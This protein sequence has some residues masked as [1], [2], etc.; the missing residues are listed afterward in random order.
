[1]YPKGTGVRE[2]NANGADSHN[3]SSSRGA[4]NIP[5]GYSDE[6]SRFSRGNASSVSINGQYSSA[7]PTHTVPSIFVNA[8]GA[9]PYVQTQSNTRP[10]SLSSDRASIYSSRD[11][12]MDTRVPKSSHTLTTTASVLTRNVESEKKPQLPITMPHMAPPPLP[13]VARS[14]FSNAPTEPTATSQQPRASVSSLLKPPP[15]FSTMARAPVYSYTRHTGQPSPADITSG[16][17]I[18]NSLKHSTPLIS[19]S[20]E[21][22]KSAVTKADL[23]ESG[24]NTTRRSPH[25]AQV[26]QSVHSLPPSQPPASARLPVAS[27]PQ[28]T[29]NVPMSQSSV[30]TANATAGMTSLSHVNPEGVFAQYIFLLNHIYHLPRHVLLPV[31]S[32][33]SILTLSS[34]IQNSTSLPRPTSHIPAVS[35]PVL[36]RIITLALRQMT[37]FWII[38][39][40]SVPLKYAYLF[41]E[42]SIKGM[43]EK[44]V[45]GSYTASSHLSGTNM[46]SLFTDS[47]SLQMSYQAFVRKTHREFARKFPDVASTGVNATPASPLSTSAFFLPPQPSPWAS[48]FNLFT[49]A[50]AVVR[51]VEKIL[52]IGNH[53]EKVTNF[54]NNINAFLGFPQMSVLHPSSTLAM[55]SMFFSPQDR[56]RS[57]HTPSQ[58]PMLE[59]TLLFKLFVQFL[60][61]ASHSM[62]GMCINAIPACPDESYSSRLLATVS[63]TLHTQS[64]SMDN[65]AFSRLAVATLIQRPL[66]LHRWLWGS[67]S[68]RK[69]LTRKAK[70]E[71]TILSLASWCENVILTPSRMGEGIVLAGVA[72]SLE[73]FSLISYSE[74]L[75]GGN[76]AQQT[77]IVS[78]GR[79]TRVPAVT[80]SKALVTSILQSASSYTLNF[81]RVMTFLVDVGL[82]KLLRLPLYVWAT[83]F[84]MCSQLEEERAHSPSSTRI[85]HEGQSNVRAEHAITDTSEKDVPVPLSPAS[86]DR[87]LKST[88]SASMLPRFLSL[89]VVTYVIDVLSNDLPEW[90][91]K[92]TSVLQQQ[93]PPS[94]PLEEAAVEFNDS[95]IPY[96]KFI[97]VYDF[98]KVKSNVQVVKKQLLTEVLTSEAKGT[99]SLLSLILT[100]GSE[101]PLESTLYPRGTA[102][103]GTERHT[104]E[105]RDSVQEQL[106]ASK[107]A[108]PAL[109]S[110]LLAFSTVRLL[111]VCQV[112]AS[113]LTKAKVEELLYS[114]TRE[115]YSVNARTSSVAGAT[116]SPSL[117]AANHGGGMSTVTSIY[118]AA[119]SSE[120][121]EDVDDRWP[122][123]LLLEAGKVLTSR[124]YKVRSSDG[125]YNPALATNTA[126]A[127]YDADKTLRSTHQEDDK[128]DVWDRIIS[129]GWKEIILLQ[130][131]LYSR[132]LKAPLPSDYVTRMMNR[133]PTVA[134]LGPGISSKN[135]DYPSIG[136]IFN[137][138]WANIL[139][140]WVIPQRIHKFASLSASALPIYDDSTS[141]SDSDIEMEDQGVRVKDN[142]FGM[143]VELDMIYSNPRMFEKQ[144]NFKQLGMEHDEQFSRWLVKRDTNLA[145]R[146]IRSLSVSLSNIHTPLLQSPAIQGQ[147]GRLSQFIG[148]SP[149]RSPSLSTQEV[150][151]R[152]ST[153]PPLDLLEVVTPTS[154]SQDGLRI[155]LPEQEMHLQLRS[156][157]AVAP[158][159]LPLPL[160]TSDK[161]ADEQSTTTVPRADMED[162]L[163]SPTQGRVDIVPFPLPDCPRVRILPSANFDQL[164]KANESVSTTVMSIRNALIE[165]A[166]AR[167]QIMQKDLWGDS[168]VSKKKRT[169]ESGKHSIASE[170]LPRLRKRNESKNKYDSHPSKNLRGNAS[171]VSAASDDVTS[172]MQTRAG[173]A[174]KAQSYLKKKNSHNLAMVAGHSR[175]LTAM[176]ASGT[177][178]QSRAKFL[179]DIS[180]KRGSSVYQSSSG[181]DNS[182]DNVSVSEYTDSDQDTFYSDYS[183]E[184]DEYSLEVLA[185]YPVDGVL[186]RLGLVTTFRSKNA[187][188]SATEES[189]TSIHNT[190]EEDAHYSDSTQ[191]YDSANRLSSNDSESVASFSS[192]ERNPRRLRKWMDRTSENI[193]E[194]DVEHGPMIMEQAMEFLNDAVSDE[195]EE[196][197]ASDVVLS[198]RG[199]QPLGNNRN[200]ASYDDNDPTS[201][202]NL[203]IRA[204]VPPIW[205]AGDDDSL[206]D[207][208]PIACDMQ[209]RKK[210][211]IKY[212]PVELFALGFSSASEEESDYHMKATSQ[213]NEEIDPND[214]DSLYKSPNSEQKRNR[215]AAR[216]SKLRKEEHDDPLSKSNDI[217]YDTD[218]S[219]NS[220]NWVDTTDSEGDAD[221]QSQQTMVGTYRSISASNHGRHNKARYQDTDSALKQQVGLAHYPPSSDTDA[222]VT[223]SSRRAHS[224]RT[225]KG[226]HHSGTRSSYGDNAS[227]YHSVSRSLNYLD[228]ASDGA[229]S[230]SGATGDVMNLSG[231]DSAKLYTIQSGQYQRNPPFTRNNHPYLPTSP[232]STLNT[233][234][235]HREGFA[236][237][238]R[239]SPYSLQGSLSDR[240]PGDIPGGEYQTLRRKRSMFDLNEARRH[241]SMPAKS[242][243]DPIQEQKSPSKDHIKSKK[244]GPSDA[245]T[246]NGERKGVGSE[247]DEKPSSAVDTHSRHRSTPIEE[248]GLCTDCW[249]MPSK[250]LEELD[251]LQKILETEMT[252]LRQKMEMCYIWDGLEGIVHND[253]CNNSPDCLHCLVTNQRLD[254]HTTP[255]GSGKRSVLK[256]FGQDPGT[257]MIYVHA[258]YPPAIAEPQVQFMLQN[259]VDKTIQ[260]LFREEYCLNDL[261]LAS[262]GANFT[263]TKGPTSSTW[264]YK[265]LSTSV[266]GSATNLFPYPPTFRPANSSHENSSI[267]PVLDSNYFV[268]PKQRA[269]SMKGINLMIPPSPLHSTLSDSVE[270]ATLS[271]SDGQTPSVHSPSFRLQKGSSF[272]PNSVLSSPNVA[273]NLANPLHPASVSDA[274]YS[275]NSGPSR[276]LKNGY[277]LPLLPETPTPVWRGSVNEL[278]P[279][280]GGRTTTSTGGI[281]NELE[282]SETIQLPM[283]RPSI[284]WTE[285]H[286]ALLLLVQ[287]ELKSEA[288]EWKCLADRSAIALASKVTANPDSL[289]SPI[290]P[291][292]VKENQVGNTFATRKKKSD[293]SFAAQ[294]RMGDD[295][296]QTLLGASATGKQTQGENKH[297]NKAKKAVQVSI[298]VPGSECEVD[299]YVGASTMIDN[300]YLQALEH[301]DKCISLRSLWV[302]ALTTLSKI[303]T[304]RAL[305]IVPQTLHVSAQVTT[306]PLINLP[307]PHCPFLY[308]DFGD[309][310]MGNASASF[311]ITNNSASPSF[312]ASEIPG[313]LFSVTASRNIQTFFHKRHIVVALLLSA[314]EAAK[315]A[316]AMEVELKM[317]T[318][319]TSSPTNSPIQPNKGSRH[320]TA[321]HTPTGDEGL[322]H[323]TSPIDEEKAEQNRI[324]VHSP[325]LDTIE[326]LLLIHMFLVEDVPLLPNFGIPMLEERN[327][328]QIRE[329][330]TGPSVSLAPRSTPKTDDESQGKSSS[331]AIRTGNF[332]WSPTAASA[333][334]MRIVVSSTHPHVNSAEVSESA[335]SGLENTYETTKLR[336]Q[337]N[338]PLEDISDSPTVWK[339]Q[340][341]LPYTLPGHSRE[342]GYT[343]QDRKE[344]LEIMSKSLLQGILN[345]RICKSARGSTAQLDDGKLAPIEVPGQSLDS[346]STFDQLIERGMAVSNPF[347]DDDPALTTTSLSSIGIS[348]VSALFDTW[349]KDKDGLLKGD[350]LLHAWEVLGT[351]PVPPRLSVR[352]E[353]K[354]RH[355]TKGYYDFTTEQVLSV[356]YE[357]DESFEFRP[358]QHERGTQ[359]PNHRIRKAMQ[360]AH[361]PRKKR[362]KVSRTA[363][364]QFYS[365]LKRAKTVQSI[366]TWLGDAFGS[367]YPAT[368]YDTYTSSSPCSTLVPIFMSTNPTSSST[369]NKQPI[370]E[371]PAAGE[372]SE[373]V[374]SG[375]VA[376][377]Q[378]PSAPPLT[379]TTWG[380]PIAET[381]SDV[382]KRVFL[383]K[384]RIRPNPTKDE[385]RKDNYGNVHSNQLRR[386]IS[387]LRA[388]SKLER[389]MYQTLTYSNVHRSF[390]KSFYAYSA[391]VFTQQLSPRTSRKG[392]RVYSQ[393]NSAP[394]TSYAE[395]QPEQAVS[396]VYLQLSKEH[397]RSFLRK[398]SEGK[399]KPKF[400]SSPYN[401]PLS[402]QYRKHN[403]LTGVRLPTLTR[404]PTL[405]YSNTV[406]GPNT[407]VSLHTVLQYCSWLAVNNPIALARAFFSANIF[408]PSP[409]LDSMFFH[410]ENTNMKHKSSFFIPRVTTPNATLVPNA[411]DQAIPTNAASSLDGTKNP[412]P[413]PA[414][415]EAG[416]CEA[417]PSKAS[418][419]P[420]KNSDTL[421]FHT[422]VVS[423]SDSSDESESVAIAPLEQRAES[424]FTFACVL[425]PAI[426]F[427]SW[428]ADASFSLSLQSILLPDY[429]VT[430]SEFLE[431]RRTQPTR[432]SEVN[433]SHR[434]NS[435]PGFTHP[436]VSIPGNKHAAS[437]R[438]STG[439]SLSALYENQS[440]IT[441]TIIGGIRGS[442]ESASDAMKKDGISTV[443]TPRGSTIL[444]RHQ[445]DSSEAYAGQVAHSPGTDE[446]NT[447]N[448]YQKKPTNNSHPISTST[449]GKI[450]FNPSLFAPNS[451]VTSEFQDVHGS[452]DARIRPIGQRGTPTALS[453]EDMSMSVQTPLQLV[454]AATELQESPLNVEQTN[455]ARSRTQSSSFSEA[456]SVFKDGPDGKQSK[457]IKRVSTP[458]PLTEAYTSES[459]SSM[460]SKHQMDNWALQ[461]YSYLA[462]F[463]TAT[464]TSSSDESFLDNDP[465]YELPEVQSTLVGKSS[466][467]LETSN[468]LNALVRTHSSSN[469]SPLR[470]A[471]VSPSALSYPIFIVPWSMS[472]KVGT[473]AAAPIERD[474]STSMLYGPFVASDI[475]FYVY[476][477]EPEESE[478]MVQILGSS[479]PGKQEVAT[480]TR[481]SISPEV[482][483]T[484]TKNRQSPKSQKTVG[485]RDKR[486]SHHVENSSSEDERSMQHIATWS[487]FRR[488]RADIQALHTSAQ[489]VGSIAQASVFDWRKEGYLYKASLRRKKK[490]TTNQTL[491]SNQSSQPCSPILASK[492]RASND[493]SRLLDLHDRVR[494][495]AIDIS[496]STPQHVDATLGFHENTASLR[497]IQKRRSDSPS[498]STINIAALASGSSGNLLHSSRSAQ[499]L[500]SRSFQSVHNMQLYA[501]EMEQKD[502]SLL[503]TNSGVSFRP[504]SDTAFTFQSFHTDIGGLDLAIP[505][506]IFQTS[507]STS[508]RSSFGNAD[509]LPGS[510]SRNVSDAHID[511]HEHM[512]ASKTPDMSHRNSG[513]STPSAQFPSKASSCAPSR[514]TLSKFGTSGEHNSHVSVR[515]LLQLS[516][517]YGSSRNLLDDSRLSPMTPSAG[518]T[519]G[520]SRTISM[521]ESIVGSSGHV[522]SNTPSMAP[523]MAG[524]MIPSE[525]RLEMSIVHLKQVENCLKD[526]GIIP[527]TRFTT[528]YLSRLHKSN[529]STFYNVFS[530]KY[531][532]STPLSLSVSR[533]EY[534]EQLQPR[535]QA[536]AETAS[537][538][539]TDEPNGIVPTPVP[540]IFT[541]VSVDILLGNLW[542]YSAGESVCR[543]DE[544]DLVL[545]PMSAYY[546]AYYATA[547]NI[548]HAMAGSSSSAQRR[549]SERSL[550]FLQNENFLQDIN[551]FGDGIKSQH[552]IIASITPMHPSANASSRSL[553][554]T[555]E[556]AN[557]SN[558][559]NSSFSGTAYSPDG[560][561]VT[562]HYSI[563]FAPIVLD[564][565]LLQS[566]KLSDKRARHSIVGVPVAI[567]ASFPISEPTALSDADNASRAALNASDVRKY[568]SRQLQLDFNKTTSKNST[569]SAL[570]R[571]I[572][573][574]QLSRLHTAL[575]VLLNSNYVS[576]TSASILYLYLLYTQSQVQRRTALMSQLGA[577]G[578][579]THKQ[580][581]QGVRKAYTAATSNLAIRNKGGKG[582]GKSRRSSNTQRSEALEKQPTVTG[583]RKPSL[584]TSMPS[585]S[586]LAPR[587]SPLSRMFE[588]FVTVGRGQLAYGIYPLDTTRPED[589]EFEPVIQ[590]KFP[591][592]EWTGQSLPLNLGM[593]AFP[594]GLRIEVDTCPAPS[595]FTFALTSEDGNKLY[596]ACLTHWT[597]MSP[598]EIISMF[599]IPSNIANSSY[600]LCLPTWLD[601]KDFHSPEWIENH[602][603]YAPR[604]YILMSRFPLYTALQSTLA[605]IGKLLHLDKP[606]DWIVRSLEKPLVNSGI[607]A[608]VYSALSSSPTSVGTFLSSNPVMQSNTHGPSLLSSTNPANQVPRSRPVIP[609]ATISKQ[610]LNPHSQYLAGMN[611]D[612]LRN[613]PLADIPSDVVDLIAHLLFDVPSPPAG[614]FSV[615]YTLGDKHF[616]VSRPPPNTLPLLDV[617]V[618]LLFQC[619]DSQNI[620][621]VFTA[622]ATEN[623]ICVCSKHVHILTPVCEALQSFIFPFQLEANY[624]P[625]LPLSMGDILAA[626]TPYLIGWPST[627]EDAKYFTNDC[628]FVDLDEN[629]VWIPPEIS[630]PKLPEAQKNK[631]LKAIRL[632]AYG[633]MGM[634]E[635][636]GARSGWFGA[637]PTREDGPFYGAKYNLDLL[638]RLPRT[639]LAYPEAD[640]AVSASQENSNVPNAM[641]SPLGPRAS[642]GATG[643]KEFNRQL[644]ANLLKSRI[645]Q[646][647]LQN[648]DILT[649]LCPLAQA[650][651]LVCSQ[652]SEK[653][654]KNM[655]TSLA[656][657]VPYVLSFDALSLSA[658]LSYSPVVGSPWLRYLGTAMQSFAGNLHVQH[659]LSHAVST[660][661]LYGKLNVPFL[662]SMEQYLNSCLLNDAQSNKLNTSVDTKTSMS[663]ES[664]SDASIHDPSNEKLNRTSDTA[665]NRTSSRT[666]IRSSSVQNG[667]NVHSYTANL[668]HPIPILDR[669][670]NRDA[671]DPNPVSSAGSD[672]ESAASTRATSARS[673]QSSR[674]LFGTEINPLASVNPALVLSPLLYGWSWSLASQPP[675]SLPP[676]SSISNVTLTSLY[677]MQA[678]SNSTGM[679][680]LYSQGGSTSALPSVQLPMHPAF[681]SKYVSPLQLQH[682]P[683]SISRRESL[684]MP[685]AI[686]GLSAFR[687]SEAAAS[688]VDLDTTMSNRTKVL[689]GMVQ[690]ATS[691]QSIATAYPIPVHVF[692]QTPSEI[693]SGGQNKRLSLKRGNESSSSSVTTRSTSNKRSLAQMLVNTKQSGL[694]QEPMT[695]EEDV[696]NMYTR[697][698]FTNSL[699]DNSFSRVTNPV[700]GLI[701][702]FDPLSVR[703]AFL[704][705]F[706]SLLKY[707]KRFLVYT[708]TGLSAPPEIHALH[709]S[710]ALQKA[711]NRK[712]L[713][714]TST[715]PLSYD[716]AFLHNLSAEV[717]VQT[718]MAS[719]A[720]DSISSNRT[721]QTP[722]DQ[723]NSTTVPTIIPSNNQATQKSALYQ[724]TT[725]S[726]LTSEIMLRMLETSFPMDSLPILRVSFAATE[727]L[728]TVPTE[729][730]EFLGQL[731][732]TQYF[733]D[734][735]QACL[736]K[737]YRPGIGNIGTF[738]TAYMSEDISVTSAPSDTEGKR[739]R[740]RT[741]RPSDVWDPSANDAHFMTRLPSRIRLFDSVVN[742]KLS[743]ISRFGLGLRRG[744][745]DTSF[746]YDSSYHIRRH[747]VVP[748]PMSSIL[749]LLAP[750]TNLPYPN[751]A[752]APVPQN[753]LPS[754]KD[755]LTLPPEIASILYAAVSGFPGD[756]ALLSTRTT[757]LTH[758]WKAGGTTFSSLNYS[759]YTPNK[760]NNPYY[761]PQSE[762]LSSISFT[763]ASTP[764]PEGMHRTHQ[765]GLSGI[766]LGE[767]STPSHLPTQPMNGISDDRTRRQRAYTLER[768]LSRDRVEV[769][770][771]D[772]ATVQQRTVNEK[773][774]LLKKKQKHVQRR[775]AL[776][777]I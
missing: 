589:L 180:L 776:Q 625:I 561:R 406:G 245:N 529:V 238:P 211:R 565:L 591:V 582:A 93:Y 541:P 279:I 412:T 175:Q 359:R 120:K 259:R 166:K 633:D 734:F 671:G 736:P 658:A 652:G 713:Y 526:L 317:P 183:S 756:S 742:D 767:V 13:S 426:A 45:S 409:S 386:R 116:N 223:H 768:D 96:S 266:T 398:R 754:N 91:G 258:A 184:D 545:L 661:S 670:L 280:R 241:E 47:K 388:A 503:R 174:M 520:R 111:A 257:V 498:N 29:R 167:H 139:D 122:T 16:R 394:G 502:S 668:V 343:K 239:K 32:L 654:T 493:S 218:A 666:N 751:A 645:Q 687:Q 605:Q 71:A 597:R 233:L 330:I 297:T 471:V 42:D 585:N 539:N 372:S 726:N 385:F 56:G 580:F 491:R 564:S 431:T 476:S 161:L 721:D 638:D 72:Y 345:P 456:K 7:I 777:N 653:Y 288:I 209:P 473:T 200:S 148:G 533:G 268:G 523:G 712:A 723:S 176:L 649:A 306:P 689:R 201:T 367:P 54:S 27:A 504:R 536:K 609:N 720:F 698:L 760:H 4:A 440:P 535:P 590:E 219:L 757:S 38:Q 397:C 265:T 361:I 676:N 731:L 115:G 422:D 341:C 449:T 450:P 34:V 212:D 21:S 169:H 490:T 114:R 121:E 88:I 255:P 758:S 722:Q 439:S 531:L 240:S 592:L 11:Q 181:E 563:E 447:P 119:R 296:T 664:P 522:S 497:K 286:A 319:T 457:P 626:P 254:V 12:T 642:E 350:E 401:L 352:S 569:M 9:I 579:Q 437:S 774:L 396:K 249:T 606:A 681:A 64:T 284:S 31:H 248:E 708:Q 744:A 49:V 333:S 566:E 613:L 205:S 193:R 405:T 250:A 534:P 327:L 304:K 724:P 462:S 51:N 234:D 133:P 6:S 381:V 435:K 334:L 305:L 662:A 414:S 643:T 568:L 20:L 741:N 310:D 452:F 748:P 634:K 729:A 331:E 617:P 308:P 371:S 420:R 639:F 356:A 466:A 228:A 684:A 477:N 335:T 711:R 98:L 575:S 660:G 376:F 557:A 511:M 382:A 153:L 752:P 438:R 378:R 65:I 227:G 375:I 547:S 624:I 669:F 484:S 107:L 156:K 224:A 719:T 640:D 39:P 611:P 106:L 766:K 770:K 550:L 584:P 746:L 37:E 519:R 35:S 131:N 186:K 554:P 518:L 365:A 659:L 517:M 373:P 22:V 657:L 692:V 117:G 727:F 544:D 15:F 506:I 505:D 347:W 673:P 129:A 650:G 678:S 707:Y 100:Y 630:L 278:I 515:N 632:Y 87:L 17:S 97:S 448:A 383:R 90:K 600:T 237:S 444:T 461:S 730:R 230:D 740:K 363:R 60:I 470:T 61:F 216:M 74:A 311:D 430:D 400:Y 222:S 595:M 323:D 170:I 706:V 478:D 251:R 772:K 41:L 246:R 384:R 207:G 282:K 629:S 434:K 508:T 765:E 203:R 144:L 709:A 607:R 628:I 59:S 298:V 667:M 235:S 443:N 775:R 429:L 157:L 524:V 393:Y 701:N 369:S 509:G 527:P 132:L 187:L 191:S 324:V 395:F 151:N 353:N 283:V 446:I 344:L 43:V 78:Q 355:D 314:R 86:I 105:G 63:K 682:G 312:S 204:N 750:A 171:Y 646:G 262:Q 192:L 603:Y 145:R 81:H 759:A 472:E 328:L 769:E 158:L 130:K 358:Y 214:S 693:L 94:A 58:S 137:T 424:L 351:L 366:Q 336:D 718:A 159:A 540:P 417:S 538:D 277:L 460:E 530:W 302:D 380:F 543:D 300:L 392:S 608:D 548:V 263:Y 631:L 206:L 627:V 403:N 364:K 487:S 48:I 299:T 623:R 196:L 496:K 675:P 182:N 272:V 418:T 704:S 593:F 416:S 469:T 601:V 528:Q 738:G 113:G 480:L 442:V 354:H 691:K 332:D 229:T 615:G 411:P 36:V 95:S 399:K 410:E 680:G 281:A 598:L 309:G 695:T 560:V 415:A 285:Y 44:H 79:D 445:S 340:L 612:E 555:L 247:P 89:V 451:S 261:Y 8:A 289:Q 164:M 165:A 577:Q 441:A 513:L 80:F 199:I 587:T 546:F 586:S 717:A 728:A 275:D 231:S 402:I 459:D 19:T 516:S 558:N 377:F 112:I 696:T 549:N 226:L 683:V 271:M 267:D 101:F 423:P 739:W 663:T 198:E 33:F 177:I 374:E 553:Q 465:Y 655:N 428:L 705:F 162:T 273:R 514:I 488:S 463:E 618:N 542:G 84:L 243:L 70:K 28:P 172:N 85:Y 303:L 620:I 525:G 562:R 651:L 188:K 714:L 495:N 578:A 699:Q 762:L 619:L 337:K 747:W 572:Q 588:Y 326:V 552:E 454:G 690:E 501:S 136:D 737:C 195:G 291:M 260:P 574:P 2:K 419:V 688:V 421:S 559:A 244:H 66:R 315:K 269:Q 127:I 532:S 636:S 362:N 486:R 468:A 210:R 329:N 348:L 360:S 567:P 599:L 507:K 339:V 685:N 338:Q 276:T 108:A 67:D 293:S 656:G 62:A 82:V 610:A 149:L 236:M 155:T 14:T 110:V 26:P 755:Q 583:E 700:T 637:V 489:H 573:A 179:S 453:S 1:M 389:Y 771:L 46:Y 482:P 307:I 313:H 221:N 109:V 581:M 138:A 124:F 433:A 83:S 467:P 644:S 387:L 68:L 635:A 703:R 407:A 295:D 10:D 189:E 556:N 202:L 357:S 436:P 510:E 217:E 602:V 125:K 622:L 23:L 725:D 686:Q 274:S 745:L 99:S 92:V 342:I 432:F 321:P 404:N 152:L 616:V 232:L 160:S 551:S 413:L 390:R 252:N 53:G 408:I 571:T 761:S 521:G 316:A 672:P 76:S 256:P 3:T 677:A 146:S 697:A 732:Q 24:P 492:S 55:S 287:A 197:S 464:V 648:S 641:Q 290:E 537:K 763:R 512:N 346:V 126:T 322:K 474:T 318:N 576:P 621:T 483:I 749:P 494:P 735:T 225:E 349:D 154:P 614:Y 18:A 294:D 123:Q 142:T 270:T 75:I 320:A 102:F 194:I 163:G 141:G 264:K 25:I 325:L 52:T 57:E 73:G 674:S 773:A 253:F 168:A 292:L 679:Q 647:S 242:L 150:D 379:I 143:F 391:G 481:L 716:P 30:H 134:Y 215:D 427:G 458:G 140:L 694:L 455:I 40:D 702:G 596:C 128:L 135:P 208:D 220:F 665:I 370:S 190:A 5:L 499:N 715:I 368:S 475:M 147:S 69:L 485:K 500:Q 764:L 594:T 570:Y 213:S 743:R 185:K 103:D 50:F 710:R 753:V 479:T 604:A 104:I 118:G 301:F 173:R 77:L 178:R 425:H 733:S